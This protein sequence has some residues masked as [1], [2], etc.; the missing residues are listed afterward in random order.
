MI[1]VEADESSAVLPS[2]NRVDREGFAAFLLRARAQGITDGPLMAAIEAV[3][4]RGFV[5]AQFQSAAWGQRTVPI[6]CGETL[7]SLDLQARL[8]ASLALAE[9]HRVLEVGTGSG[10]TAA[11]LGKIVKRVYTIERYRTLHHT[12]HQRLRG[13]KLDNVIAQHGDGSLGSTDGPFDRIIVWAA[14]PSVPRAFV[15]QLVSGGEMIC[16]IGQ[17][18]EPQTLHRLTKV[19]SRFEAEE[20]GR[21]RLQTL[22]SGTAQ[23]L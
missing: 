15:D 1:S 2:I 4:R 17:E 14:F 3:P 12:A 6:A 7:E 16:A 18:D 11:L 9:S 13:L 23:T 19:G 5:P 22:R 21:V 10:Y 20:L 8:L